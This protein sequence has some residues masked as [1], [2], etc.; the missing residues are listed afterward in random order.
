L[1]LNYDVFIV[2]FFS[3]PISTDKYSLALE[4]LALRALLL[5][6]M[7]IV[8]SVCFGDRAYLLAN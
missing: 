7:V 6:G 8:Y 2:S 1:W 3:E 5:L 4:G